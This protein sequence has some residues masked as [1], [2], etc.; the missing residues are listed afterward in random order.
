[1]GLESI[2]NVAV[3]LTASV[4]SKP[5]FGAALIAA[6][7][8][9]GGSARVLGPYT[10]PSDIAS[11]GFSTSSPVY[12]AASKFFAQNPTPTQLYIGR[13]ALGFT[14]KVRFTP[15]SNTAG[16][17][18][19]VNV[20]ATAG[21]GGTLVTYTVP[22][23]TTLAAVCTALASA[24]TAAGPGTA[25][26]SSGTHI[27]WT[28]TTVGQL[29]EFQVQTPTILGFQATTTDPGIAT[30]LAAIWAE[31]QNWYGLILDSYSQNE[32]LA[33]AAWVE[34]NKRLFPF[35]TAD[36]ACA[37]NTS[38]TDVLS[39]VKADAYARSGGLFVQNSNMSYAAAAWLGSRL[40]AT[41]GS[42]TWSFKTLASVTAD[43]LPPGWDAVVLGKKGSVYTTMNSVNFT[44]GGSTGSGEW[45]DIARGVDWLTAEMQ[46]E[47]LALLLAN[48]KIP[49]DDDGLEMIANTMRG[50]MGEAVDADLLVKGTTSVTVPLAANV[51]AVDKGNRNATGI[52][53]GGKFAGAVHT[54]TLN[55]TL[56]N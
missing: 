15:S 19:N 24:I 8:S 52:K 21:V 12:I 6:Y 31:N 43:T 32:I 45:F 28:A 40:T 9:V 38:T 17:V 26:G 7:H 47:V 25:D 16:T 34:S 42:D 53:F 50:V 3:S 1:M 49:F 22:S 29:T 41:P 5:S 56:T 48:A 20:G 14:Q 10:N 54:L 37:D 33:A 51:S 46:I 23:S 18:Y 11:A 39:V 30:D 13:R 27:D 44:R 35:N 36:T 55:G 4:P 2:V